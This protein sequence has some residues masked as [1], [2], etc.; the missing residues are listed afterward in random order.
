MLIERLFSCS[1]IATVAN[2]FKSRNIFSCQAENESRNIFKS[3]TV[4]N[5]EILYVDGMM[6]Y[7]L[8]DEKF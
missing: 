3:V 8:Y 1:A 5:T 4:A 7:I 2:I 6:L